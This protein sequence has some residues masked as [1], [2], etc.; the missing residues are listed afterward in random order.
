MKNKLLIFAAALMLALLVNSYTDFVSVTKQVEIERESTEELKRRVERLK[1]DL[2]E[3][4]FKLMESESEIVEWNDDL[5]WIESNQEV[6]TWLINQNTTPF[7]EVMNLSAGE[8][9]KK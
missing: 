4:E 5:K 8:Q 7:T 9:N 1:A 3:L 2:D 6:V